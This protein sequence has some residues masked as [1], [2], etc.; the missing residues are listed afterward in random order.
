MRVTVFHGDIIDAP[1]D[2][3][4]TSTNPRLSL[5]EGTGGRVREKGGWGVLRE[6]EAILDREK[7]AT[8]QRRAK[9]ASA[10]LTSAGTL[11]FR[12][13]IH[14]VASDSNHKSSAEIVAWCVR[15]AL[16]VA[17]RAGFQRL[18]MPVF[19]TGHAHFGFEESLA[20]MITALREATTSVEE[21]VI[22]V[23]EEERVEA[24][25]RMVSARSSRA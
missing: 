7:E 5:F 14:C 18:A 24:A 15:N 19:A 2:A 4:C 1:A 22:V 13:V 11:P 9:L 23:L 3:I 10:H 17:D 20:A 12:G 16:T 6:C 25:R 8:G 21:V